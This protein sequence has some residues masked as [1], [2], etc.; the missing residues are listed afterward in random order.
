MRRD[1]RPFRNDRGDGGRGPASGPRESLMTFVQFVSQLPPNA[2]PAPEQLDRDYKEYTD[3]FVKRAAMAFFNTHR[4]VPGLRY[5]WAGG[6]DSRRV[7]VS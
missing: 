7:L 4:C 2:N 6:A 1:R 5:W 3:A